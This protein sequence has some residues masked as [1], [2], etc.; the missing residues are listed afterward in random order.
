[1][2]KK[3]ERTCFLSE[4]MFSI[5]LKIKLLSLF[6][7]A[8]LVSVS[9]S[10][11]SQV[12]KFTFELRD[13]CVKDVFHYI[14]N[15]SEFIIL[16]NEKF[17]D[18]N[19]KV[20]VTVHDETVESVL[21]QVFLSSPNSFKIY[22]RQIVIL[23]LPKL[24]LTKSA[25]VVE[26]VKHI[27]EVLDQPRTKVLTGLVSDGL[28][29][30]LIGVSIVVKGTTIGSITD[31]NG[32]FSIEVPFEAETLV[33]SYVGMKTQEINISDKISLHIIMEEELVGMEEV[34]VVGYGT[35]KKESVVGA[36]SQI[37]GA[38]LVQSGISNVTNA[39]AGKL[40]GVLTIQQT[41]E[42]GDNMS[43][44][45]IRGLSSW[46][47]SSPLVLVDGVERDFRNMDPNEI[48]TISVL[49]D[50]SATAVFGAKGANGVII[51]TTKRG[52]LGKTKMDFSGSYG[53]QWATRGRVF[54]D[55]YTTMSMWNVA[56][57][58]DQKFTQMLS[59]E[60][61]EEFR[62][63]S[64]PLKSIEYPNVNWWDELVLPFAPT[65][66]A[67]L[68]ISGGTN[69]V[70]YFASLG[71]HQ[72]DG[73]FRGTKEGHQ[74]TRFWNKRY[75]YRGN[76]D[77][78]LTKSTNLNLNLGGNIV[79]KNE[80]VIPVSASHAWRTLYFTGPGTYPA[81]YPDW[82][83]EQVPDIDYPDDSGM[84]L[85]IPFGENWTNPYNNLNDGSFNRYL[86]STLFTDL[87]LDQ[88]LDF[89]AKGLSFK[90]KVSLNTYFNNT[91]LNASYVKP[92][93]RLYFEKIGIEG[94][95]PWFR[96]NQ[97]PEV[98]KAPKV[99]LKVGGLN[100]SYYSDF[101]Y[102]M[103]LNYNNTFNRHSIS[104]IAL[105]N[106]QQRNMRLDFPYY[107]AAL[108]GRINYDYSRK[109]FAEFNIGYT[110][111]ERFA[112]GNR[113]GIFP[114]GAIGWAI[115]EEPFFK[116]ALPWMNRFKIR[117]S[118]GLVGSDIAKNRWLYISEYI[119][120][121]NYIVEDK[122]PN[123]TA[124]WEE[125][126]KRD[127]GFEIGLLNNLFAFTIDLFNEYR[128]KMLVIPKNVTMLVGNSFK[129]LNLGSIKKHGIDFEAE[130]NKI[131]SAD[132]NYFIRSNFGFNENRIINKA[133]YPYAPDYVK[134]AGKPLASESDFNGVLFPIFDGV[135]LTGSK[136]F[137]SIN[138][139]HNKSAPISIHQLNLKDYKYLNYR[140]DGTITPLD[141]YPIKGLEYPPI[142][143]SIS[144]GFSYKG[145]DFSLLFQ[146]NE[147]KYVLFTDNFQNEFT[148]GNKSVHIAQVDYWRP[149]NP[150]ATH[151]TLH[152]SASA[153]TPQLAWGG[154][155]ELVGYRAKIEDRYWRNAN[156]LR[157][158]DIYIG[159]TF[160]MK[161][162][163]N[164]AGV[165]NLN[166]YLTANN[167]LTFTKL[168]EGDPE[169]KDYLFWSYPNMVTLKFG[170][171]ASF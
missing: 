142:T 24:S 137:T 18:I 48:N 102:E 121:G 166:L 76:V 32:N 87:I 83:L 65:Y 130:F 96:A 70:K 11:Y 58:N 2:K 146:G 75:N 1:M 55:S 44:I 50:A 68:N 149:D 118:E 120:S 126:H 6:I 132:F 93:Y 123:T 14:E 16:Y 81:Y 74:D 112:P 64:S 101:Y 10:S 54:V 106:L 167:L 153:G 62:N 56:L 45:V 85:A 33:F 27:S 171:K 108:V 147:G 57:M 47:G 138:N 73:L 158:K 38:T 148:Q 66:N 22:D 37:T 17:V 154:G 86:G 3:P 143:Y 13:E 131:V 161:S 25:F 133:D 30:P 5:L 26:E 116:D 113:F 168:I 84:R 163:Q 97:G 8:P 124:Q 60:E 92:Q 67:N 119:K 99:N 42:P 144:G 31:I 103:A 136:Y 139:I 72:E 51:V 63:P 79:V 152:Y 34:V 90:G 129:E 135:V 89:I 169:R 69:F 145:F 82:V 115:S 125:A 150:N 157:L 40:S 35:Q 170:I 156:Y 49:K 165:S 21:S 46:S 9:A 36:I 12:T 98:F 94:E 52:T 7:I 43:E 77:F 39:I 114:S 28:G 53:I 141:I 4:S 95:N 117:Y 140:V 78:S 91:I 128:D 151:A 41:G 160:N 80:P 23:A 107:N 105:M 164:L 15:N 155:D 111:S 109:Y 110:G 88:K 134:A 127:L 29:Q 20:S 104:G 100:P 71:Y 122:A 59:Q 61:L 19:R 159:Y 162:L